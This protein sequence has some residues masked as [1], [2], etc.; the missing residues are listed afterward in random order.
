MAKRIKKTVITGV[1]SE[2]VETALSEFSQADSTIQKIT[3]EMELKITA[4][5]DEHADEL[6]TLQKQKDDS[7]EV[8]QVFATENKESMF[9]KTKSYKSAHGVF[10]FRTGTPKLKQLKGFTKES[11]LTLVKTLLPDYVRS[12][13][14]VA[15]DKLLADR[16]NEGMSENLKKCGLA[17]VQDETFYVEPKKEKED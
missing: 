2:Q 14:E 10:G 11:V 3:A 7:M 15:K 17:V 5:R 4:I 1:T 12:T 6:A 8:L 16:S 13:E 9:S